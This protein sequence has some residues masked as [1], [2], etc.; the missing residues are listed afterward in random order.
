MTLLKSSLFYVFASLA[1]FAS[2]ATALPW[3]PDPQIDYES[4]SERCDLDDVRATSG[5]YIGHCS[6]QRSN[7]TEYL[8]IRYAQSPVGNLRFAAPVAFISNETFEASSQPDDCPYVEDLWGNVP[9][10]LYSHAPR[11]MAQESADG[12]NAMSEDCLA[13]NV[14]A[15]PSG[16]VKKPV[17]VFLYGG[18][19][20][21]GSINNPAYIGAHMAA[22][23]D[24]LVV[25]VNFRVNIMGFA[26]AP[27]ADSNVA[28]RDVRLAVEWVRDNIEAFGGDVDH[29]TL[30]GQSQGAYLTSYY[31][32]AYPDDPIVSSF[33]QQS[34]SAFSIV[35]QSQSDKA[36][37]WRKASAAVGCH[38][39]SD[40]AVLECMRAQDL[41]TVLA[42]WA[43]LPTTSEEHPPFG[44]VVDNELIFANY[45][46]K[47]LAHEFAQKPF[48]VGS[49]ANEAG[50]YV[51]RYS[52]ANMSKPGTLLDQAAQDF[53]GF[54][55]FVCPTAAD[56]ATK[57]TAFANADTP[58]YRFEYLGDYPNLRLYPESGAYHTS[59]TSMVLGNA[60][61]LSGEKNTDVQN[62]VS[63]YL[64]HAWTTF[65]RD[66]L[67]GLERLG[68][69][70]YDAGSAT[71]V[72]L[73]KG[74]ETEASF[75]SPAKYDSICAGLEKSSEI[76]S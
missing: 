53:L 13:L 37:I 52:S 34:G 74:N 41:S 15:P 28:L 66:P 30:F 36:E 60:E 48:L 12:I 51:L 65:A 26:N 39:T 73:G 9:G 44:A 71:L 47:T 3:S 24:V 42:A 4:D 16:D 43:A 50:F 45:T 25:T 7:I 59:E 54:G 68:W 33:I 40:T 14:W 69:P 2:F 61:E 46:A 67:H 31:A 63:R 38:Q 32:Y 22:N 62:K 70:R 5:H 27:G 11:I 49:N 8:G 6:P 58:I 18:G 72:Q 10:E 29:I 55:L 1:L 35:T 19:F 20:E 75:A 64:Q 56:A 17:M 57:A 76:I 23:E 21:R